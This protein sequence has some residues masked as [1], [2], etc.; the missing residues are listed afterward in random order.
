M[1]EA[2]AVQDMMHYD[3]VIMS[4]DSDAFSLGECP[5]EEGFSGFVTRLD[6][7]YAV[8]DVIWNVIESFPFNIGVSRIGPGNECHSGNDAVLFA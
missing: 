4:V 6:G 7:C 8:D 3:I 5:V 2:I 1:G